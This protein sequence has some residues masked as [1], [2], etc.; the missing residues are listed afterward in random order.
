MSGQQPDMMPSPISSNFTRFQF[1]NEVS[2][3]YDNTRFHGYIPGYHLSMPRALH[4]WDGHK[5]RR[6]LKIC[7][8]S[9][10]KFKRREYRPEL[11]GVKDHEIRT[12][13]NFTQ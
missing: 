10:Q 13:R 4:R 2:I 6:G 11:L 1:P 8:T 9:W 5:F 7:A 3:R 12:V